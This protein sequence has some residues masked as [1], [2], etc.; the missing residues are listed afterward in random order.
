MHIVLVEPSR[1]VRHIVSGYG[2]RWGHSFVG[3][4]DAPE[5][6][7]YLCAT[8]NARALITVA[9]LA[10]N[11]GLNLISAAREAIG[12]YRPLYSIL[13][14]SHEER[15]SL[16]DALD[17]GADDFIVKPPDPEEFRARLQAA[18]RMTSMQAEL[19][20]LARTDCLTGLL[21]RRAFVADA[22][23]EIQRAGPERP[24]SMLLCDLDRFKRINDE[25]GHAAGD[26]VLEAAAS[27]IKRFGLISGRI[28]G[29]EFA[30]LVPHDLHQ[31]LELA[32]SLR[33][34]ISDISVHSGQIP[35]E[36]S[37]SIGV[38]EWRA[39]DNLDTL[40]RRCDVGLYA[41]KRLSRN[42][43]EPGESSCSS[44]DPAANN[45]A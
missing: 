33:I 8:E 38:S 16:V 14:S 31:A 26:L 34:A 36:C 5:A 7:D 41:A 6:L 27:E 23:R 18:D 24:V 22:E 42:R 35:I 30:L 25:H 32:E 2:E 1:T 43:V 9:E 21:N 40:L 45:V 4:S 13:M 17:H 37:C 11:S 19:A 3:F 12:S 29:E 39:G 10:S 28:G 20:R 44:R 15:K